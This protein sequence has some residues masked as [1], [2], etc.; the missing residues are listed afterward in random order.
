MK[1]ERVIK[2][3]KQMRTRQ[4]SWTV[5]AGVGK[6]RLTVVSTQHTVYSC[7]SIY[8]LLYHFPHNWQPTF[9]HVMKND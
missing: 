6:S 2:K 1:Q 8:Q 5:N 7:I 3:K 4:S 9:V